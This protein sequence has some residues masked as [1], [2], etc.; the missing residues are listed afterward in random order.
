MTTSETRFEFSDWQLDGRTLRLRYALTNSAFGDQNFEEVIRLPDTLPAPDAADPAIRA[1]IELVHFTFGVSYYKVASPP[2]VSAR[3]VAEPFGKFL[4]MLYSEGLGEFYFRNAIS[5]EKRAHFERGAHADPQASYARPA[6]ERALVLVGGGKDSVV[7]REALRYA[8]VECDAISMGTAHWIESSARAMDVTHHVIQRT[9]DPKLFALNER[10]APNGHVPISACIAAVTLLAAIAGGYTAVVAANERSADEGNTTWSGIE[11]NHQWSKSYRF[12]TAFRSVA[13]SLIQ[14]APHYLSI[15][16]PLSELS[17]SRKFTQ[18]PRYH[19]AVSSCN[20]NFR[21][22]EP[23]GERRWCGEC[24]K[25]VFVYLMVAAHAEPEV[26][27]NIFGSDF[28]DD[29]KNLD[30]LADLTGVGGMKPFECVGTP[31]E[32]RAAL[33]RLH[34]RGLLSPGITLWYERTVNADATRERED[35]TESMTASDAYTLPENWRARLDAY[36]AAQ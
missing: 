8:G 29:P 35:W 24:P 10:G 23:R 36:L 6:G 2:R 25:C 28:L 5:L 34:A 19:A 12:E 11:V 33:G 7:A 9:I 1:A 31:L 20:K 21:I 15:L 4:D 32:C 26:V 3:P 14:G 17:I 27:T 18:H 22:H 30:T 16:R 13:E